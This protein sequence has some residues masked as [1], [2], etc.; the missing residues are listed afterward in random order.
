ML[1]LYNAM[2][3]TCSQKVRITLAEKGIDFVEHRLKLF[4]QEQLRPEYL[5]LNPNGVVPTL[6]HDGVPVIDS[7]V[8]MEYL[9]EV[10]PDHSLT[11]Q[12]PRQRD[13]MRAWMRFFEE[14][15]TA[16]VRYPSYQVAFGRHFSEMSE[17]EFREVASSKP[18]RDKFL[19]E[20]DKDKGFSQ[21]KI[22]QAEKSVRKTV[23]RM[24]TRLKDQC[25]LV[26]AKISLADICILP[27]LIRMEDLG[28]SH[29]WSDLHGVQAWLE[30]MKS[31]PSFQKAF[32]TG[33]LLS[34]QYPDLREK[35]ARPA[36][37]H[38]RPSAYRAEDAH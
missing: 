20:M 9:D 33:A 23:V 24:E 22:E 26:G 28:Y 35:Q 10:F 16:A 14:V 6:V 11:P 5:K 3:S 7:S 30:R 32:Y 38:D 13:E 4:K 8:I 27:P 18:L 15:P 17:S 36:Q 25:Y 21:E 37:N 34:E 1:E 2:Q 12:S 19:G 29:L 31:R